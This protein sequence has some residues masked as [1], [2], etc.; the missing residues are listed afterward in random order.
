[1][2]DNPQGTI[3]DTHPCATG[4]DVVRLEAALR[5]RLT[6]GGVPE[7]I[8]VDFVPRH[9]STFCVQTGYVPLVE[10]VPA[11]TAVGVRVPPRLAA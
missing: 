8:L 5:T 7:A 11:I 10:A 2:R 9:K 6:S 4:E 1:L 3:A